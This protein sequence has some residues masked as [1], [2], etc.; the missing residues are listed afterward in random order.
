MYKG[1]DGMK[2]IDQRKSAG[3]VLRSVFTTL[4]NICVGPFL[5]KT[6]NG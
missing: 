2:K 4:S 3:G 1:N 6:V 5:A